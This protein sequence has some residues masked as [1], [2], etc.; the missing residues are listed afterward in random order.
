[1]YLLLMLLNPELIKFKVQVGA[2]QNK[3]PT[4]ILDLYLSIGNV[5]PKKDDETG[6]TKYFIGTM[7]TYKEAEALKNELKVKGLTD[8]FIVG[9]FNGKIITAQEALDL[10]K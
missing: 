5:I 8:A 9:D 6:L 7:K 10:L 1:M 2:F 4:N 3:I